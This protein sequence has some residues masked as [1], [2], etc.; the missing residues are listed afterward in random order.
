MN[1]NNL[2]YDIEILDSVSMS[3]QHGRGTLLAADLL[4][5]VPIPGV[6]VIRGDFL[7]DGTTRLIKFCW[8]VGCDT[9]ANVY[10]NDIQSSEICGAYPSA[11]RESSFCR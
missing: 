7:V 8:Q 9:A 2:N 6:K 10:G 3:A 11:P 4:L 1:S 5:V